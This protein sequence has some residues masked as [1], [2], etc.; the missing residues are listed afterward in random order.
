M[1]TFL[2]D[3][4]FCTFTSESDWV[5]MNGKKMFVT[6]IMTLTLVKSIYVLAQLKQW[7]YSGLE[8]VWFEPKECF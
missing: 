8:D 1:I 6:T 4:Q 7:K 5:H 3:A 2:L